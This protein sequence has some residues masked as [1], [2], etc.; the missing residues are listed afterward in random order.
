MSYIGRS[1]WLVILRWKIYDLIPHVR[2]YIMQIRWI[3]EITKFHW[4]QAIMRDNV[5]QCNC[6]VRVIDPRRYCSIC[7][8]SYGTG[9]TARQGSTRTAFWWPHNVC[10]QTR[11][12]TAN[13]RWNLSSIRSTDF[14]THVNN[15]RV[16]PASAAENVLV[17]AACHVDAGR[18]C[19]PTYFVTHLESV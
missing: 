6:D 3:F 18:P 11:R 4:L 12:G 15:G 19:V 10:Q 1:S 16:A 9:W 14:Y 8:A 5:Y 17:N 13:W 7:R 2:G